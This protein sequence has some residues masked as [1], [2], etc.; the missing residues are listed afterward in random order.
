MERNYPTNESLGAWWSQ[1][2]NTEL[3]SPVIQ[4]K[5]QKSSVYIEEK[6]QMHPI[7]TAH[8]MQLLA[9]YGHPYFSQSYITI[10][11]S[12]ILAL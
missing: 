11:T 12:V 8:I 1:K 7:Q 6:I 10:N 3:R 5:Y 9:R 2:R 4:E